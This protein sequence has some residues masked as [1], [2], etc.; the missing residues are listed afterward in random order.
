[1][2]H[3]R[4]SY[5]DFQ[6]VIYWF[7]HN[8][9]QFSLHSYHISYIFHVVDQRSFSWMPGFGEITCRKKNRRNNELIFWDKLVCIRFIITI[10]FFFLLEIRSRIKSSDSR[11]GTIHLMKQQYLHT[12]QSHQTLHALSY[13]C[14]VHISCALYYIRHKRIVLV[15]DGHIAHAIHIEIVQHTEKSH[16]WR[17]WKY[18]LIS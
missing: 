12:P 4:F 16:V 6:L 10:L 18:C 15:G 1:M 2:F 17:P 13:I 14:D 5:G 7:T 3:N 8:T 9:I 11:A